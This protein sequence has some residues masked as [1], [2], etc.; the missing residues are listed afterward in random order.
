[1]LG[2]LVSI[3]AAPVPQPGSSQGW[4]KRLIAFLFHRRA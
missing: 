4:L 2:H 3:R 1:M